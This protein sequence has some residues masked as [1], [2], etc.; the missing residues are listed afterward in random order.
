MTEKERRVDCPVD[1][2]PGFN[3][4]GEFANAFRIM[5]DSGR[6][7]FLDFLRYSGSEGKAVIVSRV[8]VFEDFLP[9]IRS[10]LGTMMTEIE[11]ANAAQAASAL[12][13]DPDKVN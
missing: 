13:I 12:S 4:M 8:R 1:F 11:A 6:E 2:P 9:A 7:F 5:H 10:R 3:K